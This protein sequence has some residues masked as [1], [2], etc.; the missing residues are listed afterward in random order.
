MAA[1]FHSTNLLVKYRPGVA[2]VLGIIFHNT[3]HH[4]IEECPQGMKH[5]GKVDEDGLTLFENWLK[6]ERQEGR[7]VSYVFVEVPGNPTLET[8]DTYRLKKLVSSLSFVASALTLLTL[9]S[10]KNMASSS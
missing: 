1:I 9:S 10:L 4:L 3:Y 5:F 8:P 6:E 7:P 2:V